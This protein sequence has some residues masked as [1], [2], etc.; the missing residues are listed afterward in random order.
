[1]SSRARTG[2]LRPVKM[3]TTDPLPLV[4]GELVR[5]LLISGNVEELTTLHFSG[6]GAP[7]GSLGFF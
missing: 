3:R 4:P 5:V 6:I 7:K 2:L 1:M